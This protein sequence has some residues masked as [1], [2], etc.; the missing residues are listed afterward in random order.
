MTTIGYPC[1][2][3]GT[4]NHS[5]IALIPWLRA[6]AT[7]KNKGQ[8]RTPDPNLPPCLASVAACGSAA[9]A[10]FIPTAG[11]CLRNRDQ[12]P[13]V[14]AAVMTGG[15]VTEASLYVNWQVPGVE[16]ATTW[17]VATP[18]ATVA[19]YSGDKPAAV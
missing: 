4:A 13:L 1:A 18:A 6:R 9:Y 14:T 15:T 3:P 12:Q 5:L 19:L 17:T 8:D 16:A 7:S 2:H 10:D 11:L